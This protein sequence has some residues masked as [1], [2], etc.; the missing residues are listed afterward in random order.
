MNIIKK[1]NTS[2]LSILTIA[3]VYPYKQKKNEKYM[4]D[5]QIIH[6]K[7]ILYAWK[8]QI[9]K[10][11]KNTLLYSNNK[12]NNLPDMIDRAVQEEEFSLELKNQYRENKTIIKIERTLIKIKNE[13]FGYCELCNTE[14]GIKRLEAK[15]TAS[16]C[17]D[18]QSLSEIKNKQRIKLSF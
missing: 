1:N 11:I 9:N 16:L 8:K 5:N 2:S 10:K 15:P 4:N 17:I 6:F 13:N 14:I 12:F 18:C 7:K 3:G